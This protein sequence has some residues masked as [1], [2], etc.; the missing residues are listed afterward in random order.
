MQKLIELIQDHA[1][2][3]ADDAA[4]LVEIQN[5]PVV[6]SEIHD[7]PFANRA[8]AQARARAARNHRHARHQRRLDDVRRLLH[9]FGKRHRLRHDLV[10]R[11]VRGKKLK[12]EIVKRDLAVRG[13]Q[14]CHL[15]G[16]KHR[17]QLN[18]ATG[19]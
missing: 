9:R 16:G 11:G 7:Q 10:G 14:R 18:G 12:R 1:G 8:A 6:P 17:Q 19:N 3:D 15:L 2:A 4:F 5:L 13:V